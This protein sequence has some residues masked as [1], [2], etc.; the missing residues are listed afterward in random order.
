MAR[1]VQDGGDLRMADCAPRPPQKFLA[2][3]GEQVAVEGDLRAGQ[4]NEHSTRRRAPAGAAAG[5][6]ASHHFCTVSIA[7][8]AVVIVGAA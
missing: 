6:R 4:A 1:V 3:R 7:A 2:H 5:S 8:G